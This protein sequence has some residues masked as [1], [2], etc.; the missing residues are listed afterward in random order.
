MRYGI[1]LSTLLV[2]LSVT[3]DAKQSKEK[4]MSRDAIL[5]TLNSHGCSM[6]PHAAVSNAGFVPGLQKEILNLSVTDRQKA[7]SYIGMHRVAGFAGIL[8]P[9]AARST[10]VNDQSAIA[11]VL[12][13]LPDLPA[14]GI[15][16]ANVPA[17]PTARQ[18]FYLALVNASDRSAALTALKAHR[19]K[20]TDA[21]AGLVADVVAARLG[22]VSVRSS[23]S[24]KLAALD[25]Q[26]IREIN[27]LLPN[28]GK[29]VSTAKLFKPWLSD[30]REVGSFNHRQAEAYTVRDLGL[31]A[32]R[33]LGV[34]VP[35]YPQ[36]H[37]V[38]ADD[39]LAQKGIRALDA[40]P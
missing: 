19:T 32:V 17:N 16:L 6:Q 30:K 20:E 10:D 3:G 33:T 1:F 28:L 7:I 39:A 29:D 40:I 14:A 8:I 37:M 4:I 18:Y 38:H 24:A 25:V 12:D 31:W 2:S 22:D 5:S 34:T 13:K 36:D 27:G 26:S 9:Y 35:D 21:N 23:V 11:H 15:V